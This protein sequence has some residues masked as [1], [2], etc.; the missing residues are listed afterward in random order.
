[1]ARRMITIDEK[2][3]KA[4]A[5]V[6]AAKEKYD[7]ALDEL[8][9]LV[10]RRKQQDDKKVLEAYH[11]GDKTAEEIIEFIKSGNGKRD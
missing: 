2:I 4:Q 11:A 3:E 6:I 1:M 9:K 8:E 7:A 10:A 5:A